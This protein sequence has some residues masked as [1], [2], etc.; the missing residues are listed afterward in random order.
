M[1]NAIVAVSNLHALT[2]FSKLIR[3]YHINSLKHDT[4]SRKKGRRNEKKEGKKE[5]KKEK[6]GQ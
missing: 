4:K 6:R 1:I 3:M 2:N 5:K